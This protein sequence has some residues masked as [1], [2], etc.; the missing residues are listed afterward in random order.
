MNNLV[1][2]IGNDYDSRIGNHSYA[3][4]TSGYD[5]R[6]ENDGISHYFQFRSSTS[7]RVYKIDPVEL[8]NGRAIPWLALPLKVRVEYF[9]VCFPD[10][11]ANIENE[12]FNIFVFG[13]EEGAKKNEQIKWAKAH[14]IWDLAITLEIAK[15]IGNFEKVRRLETMN[16]LVE[17]KWLI[18]VSLDRETFKYY[19]E[20]ED[21][22]S[23][24]KA[25]KEFGRRA[26]R[27]AKLAGVPWKIGTLV[28]D[29]ED[30][31]YAVT[32]LKSIKASVGTADTKLSHELSC[33]IALRTEALKKMLGASWD[34]L[35]IQHSQ[36]KTTALAHYLLKEK[37]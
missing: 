29:I 37:I 28:N 24:L 22:S 36:A 4:W 9:K 6:I 34:A 3:M 14:L 31:S 35:S 13:P 8:E 7:D 25:R 10:Q 21:Y 30:D 15:E 32:I 2:T 11:E 27:R 1:V 12:E 33:G 26:S 18:T 19:F 5:V 16:F 20:I 17:E 23:V